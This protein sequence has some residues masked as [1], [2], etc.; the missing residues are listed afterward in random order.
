MRPMGSAIPMGSAVPMGSV[1]PMRSPW[2]SAR[3]NGGTVM[4]SNSAFPITPNYSAPGTNGSVVQ[5]YSKNTAPAGGVG[6]AFEDR[7]NQRTGGMLKIVAEVFPEGAAA[8]W[9]DVCDDNEKIL[10]GDLLIEVN[11]ERVAGMDMKTLAMLV[12]GP[13]DTPVILRLRSIKG[14]NEFEVELMRQV[15]HAAMG[16]R[17]SQASRVGI[18]SAQPGSPA[19]GSPAPRAATPPPEVPRSADED[20]YLQHNA[21][22]TTMKSYGERLACP[23]FSIEAVAED[24][25]AQ[26]GMGFM[27]GNV[28]KGSQAYEFGFRHGEVIEAIDSISMKDWTEAKIKSLLMDAAYTSVQIHTDKRIVPI[29]RDCDA[30]PTL[31]KIAPLPAQPMMRMQPVMQQMQMAPMPRTGRDASF[32]PFFQ[33][34]RGQGSMMPM[35]SAPQYMAGPPSSSAMAYA[36]PT[37]GGHNNYAGPNNYSTQDYGYMAPG[38]QPQYSTVQ[39]PAWGR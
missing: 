30:E 33:P 29:A 22:I 9:N 15:P 19:P 37:M 1:M 23:G 2:G 12:P 28:T 24:T 35:Q 4:M 3:P 7:V 31:F 34:S 6:V 13:V 39:T 21:K 11:G 26:E 8:N 38:N 20:Y 36:E 32:V 25:K 14:N 16:W 10:A 17:P 27:I 18:G 5:Q